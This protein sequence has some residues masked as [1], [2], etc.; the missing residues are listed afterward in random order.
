[1]RQVLSWLAVLLLLPSV[2]AIT[3]GTTITNSTTL[4]ENLLNCPGNGINI[5]AI[6]ITLDCQGHTID[7]TKVEDSAGVYAEGRTGLHVLNCRIT[8]FDDGIMLKNG[9]S[10]ALL[11]KN[12]IS[13]SGSGIHQ[14]F[15]PGSRIE[16][17]TIANLTGYGIELAFSSWENDIS[18]NTITNTH[19]PI[20]AYGTSGWNNVTYNTATK[21]TYG[22]R[23]YSGSGYNRIEHNTIT[24]SKYNGITLESSPVRTTDNIVRYNTIV[25]H[26]VGVKIMA[27]DNNI[28]EYNNMINTGNG[29]LMYRN[30]WG[31]TDGTG[32]IF[33]YNTV[34]GSSIG[35]QISQGIN[36]IFTNNIIATG[37]PIRV[38]RCGNTFTDNIG[39]GGLPVL[40]SETPVTITGG[41]YSQ[42]LLCDADGSEIS[43]VTLASGTFGLQGI[44]LEDVT[45]QNILSQGNSY[46]IL[47]SN[48]TRITIIGNTL[49]SNSYSGLRLNGVTYSHITGNRN[50]DNKGNAIELASSTSNMIWNNTFS[51]QYGYYL[52]YEDEL[53]TGNAWNISNTGNYWSNF[54]NNPGYPDEYIIP[55][56]G[57]GIDYRPLNDM[58]SDG[59]PAWNDCN[60]GNSYV[61]PGARETCNG[62]DDNCNGLIDEIICTPAGKP[63]TKITLG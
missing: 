25:Q 23:F 62:I 19:S 60:D 32:N 10:G 13:S 6:D 4:T 14:Y 36:N 2:I 41:S 16:N 45:I 8:D 21:S 40:Y 28:I 43:G 1:M 34:N 17:N 7:G 37:T 50:I 15:T 24:N 5:G 56:D 38:S 57:G 49:S 46:G 54:L 27:S 51:S 52:A 31:G 44:N 47:L 9:A 18:G 3:C 48:S 42:I 33:A 39:I 55:G 53:S 26:P 63:K 12:T 35:M 11:E 59:Y 20:Y 22:F 58:D 29:I 30:D 61:H